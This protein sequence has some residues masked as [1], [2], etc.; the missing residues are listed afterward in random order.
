MFIIFED[1]VIVVVTAVVAILLFAVSAAFLMIAEGFAAAVRR[2][3]RPA[4][5]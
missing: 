4:T 1:T 2:L 5:S 3:R